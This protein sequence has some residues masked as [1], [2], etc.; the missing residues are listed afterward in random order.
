MTANV[1][2]LLSVGYQKPKVES[3]ALRIPYP[4]LTISFTIVLAILA[5]FFH[6]IGLGFVG[7]DDPAYVTNNPY[8]R[9]ALSADTVR[10]IFLSLDP[11][12]WFP[13]TR[14]SLLVDF[15]LFGLKAAAYHAENLFIHCMASLVL[16]AFLRRATGMR[17]PAAFVALVFAL[18]PLH[19]ESVVWIAERKDVL[20]AFFW[21]ATL[22]AWQRY[23]VRPG[24]GRY[25]FALALFCLGLMSKPMIV[26]LPVLLFF[27]DFWPLRRRISARNIAEKVPFLLLSVA[28][29]AVTLLAQQ[30]AGAIQ[31]LDLLPLPLRA[32][33]AVVTVAIYIGRALWP[34][35]LWLPY[36]YADRL[37]EW[38]VFMVTVGIVAVSVVVLR[39]LKKRPYLPV[40]WFWFLVT[41]IPV[42]GLVQVGPQARGDRYMY[43][44]LVGLTL[45]LAWGLAE[46]VRR[47]P[48]L[49]LWVTVLGI[50]VCLAM[51]IRTRDQTEY[52]S[53][54]RLLF[55]HAIEE[56]NNNYV[57]WNFLGQTMAP[58]PDE[59]ID[60]YRK[61]L[62]IRPDDES[63]NT[64]LANA[65]YDA[66][67]TEESV[68]AYRQVL[69]ITPASWKA[70]GTLGT[71]LAK[72]GQ[73]EEAIRELEAAVRIN[74]RYATAHNDLGSLLSQI[75]ERSGEGLRHLET[76][77]ELE[78]AVA[79]AQCNL[80]QLL[81]NTPGRLDEAVVHLKAAL[82]IDPG[83]AAAHRGLAAVYIR[84]G[85]ETEAAAHLVA[86]QRIEPRPEL[87]KLLAKLRSE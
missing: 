73:P 56:D 8:I 66:G 5:A 16:F 42:I 3:P 75:P 68:A 36:A 25:L 10:W 37:P 39:Q 2:E 28:L 53:D 45:M 21:F 34:T 78:P 63:L 26:T 77:V 15:R 86:A 44:P 46:T 38:L 24:V 47:W 71:A 13:V 87:Q 20:C 31:T 32:Q 85:Q 52:W 17:W 6:V 43:V 81:V 69:R 11:D 27:L 70:H 40:G 67:R 12:N 4:D 76:A 50:T 33:N 79:R 9:G 84:K 23:T 1:L 48:E 82:H 60:C 57:A 61:G 49:R 7:F 29:M 65:L 30:K 22:W 41:L 80:G 35:H 51:I 19:V 58:S 83:M 59:A 62:A 18:H 64:N 55:M 54:T 72:T 14:L 74:P